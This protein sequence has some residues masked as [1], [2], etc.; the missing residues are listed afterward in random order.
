MSTELVSRWMR[1]CSNTMNTAQPALPQCAGASR[2]GC[3][4]AGGGGG[5]GAPAAGRAAGRRRCA[6]RDR[7]RSRAG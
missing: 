5:G 1:S 7:G 2:Q 3:V 4:C 6:R